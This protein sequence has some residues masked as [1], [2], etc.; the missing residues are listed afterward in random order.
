MAIIEPKRADIS[1]PQKNKRYSRSLRF[2]HW[3]NTLIICGSLLT[4]LVNSTLLDRSQATFLKAELQQSGTAITDQQA[5]GFTH[6]ME[7]QVWGIHIYFGYALAALLLF[8]IVSEIFSTKK[9]KLFVKLKSAYTDYF[10]IKKERE[11]AMHEL[12]V[13]SLYL[14]FYLL[15]LIMVTTGLLLAFE[16]STGISTDVN[17]SVK[18]IHGFCMYLILG[19]ITVHVV[20]VFLAERKD[21]KGIISDMVNGG[22]DNEQ[23]LCIF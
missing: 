3:A 13:K 22:E 11:L 5:R 18:E 10:I 1:S 7:D 6:S 9:S 23:S 14:F 8:R 2:W 17:H 21:S 20:G 4:V 16:D 15:L 12:V 19:F